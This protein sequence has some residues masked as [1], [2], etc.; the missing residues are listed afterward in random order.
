MLLK[1]DKTFGKEKTD[2]FF[3]KRV[4][5]KDSLPLPIQASKEAEATKEFATIMGAILEL[6]KLHQVAITEK[7]KDLS[8]LEYKLLITKQ[9]TTFISATVKLFE[10]PLQGS[11]PD[12]ILFI[13]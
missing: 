11:N 12:Q 10:T 3:A 5:T 4:R 1:F 2:N 6:D 7:L 8:T 13:P 9:Y